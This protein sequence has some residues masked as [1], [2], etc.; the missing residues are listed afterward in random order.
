MA[1]W[2]CG[3]GL[4]GDRL[5]T[6]IWAMADAPVKKRWR[7]SRF[8]IPLV[9]IGAGTVAADPRC[10]FPPVLIL[11]APVVSSIL[12]I[13]RWRGCHLRLTD[14][15]QFALVCGVVLCC[16]DDFA[17]YW[18]PDEGDCCWSHTGEWA[19]VRPEGSH[20]GWYLAYLQFSVIAGTLLGATLS[21]GV[22]KQS[23]PDKRGRGFNFGRFL[24][25]LLTQIGFISLCVV[26]HRFLN[27][28]DWCSW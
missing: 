16:S 26:H 18:H 7:W 22:T 15:V 20:Y 9:A 24:L 12:L 25:I 23:D 4:S 2:I 17:S 28:W 19:L 27:Y 11:G 14:L 6:R 3:V 10:W 13:L 8:V 5:A 21:S 1:K